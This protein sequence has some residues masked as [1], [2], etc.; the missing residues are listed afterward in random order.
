MSLSIRPVLLG[1][2]YN[3]LVMV[4]FAVV[5]GLALAHLVAQFQWARFF[6]EFWFFAL[7]ALSLSA[8]FFARAKKSMALGALLSFVPYYLVVVP[9]AF[10]QGD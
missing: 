6:G 4:G 2:T 7:V 9:L 5:Y 3:L 8:Y 1:L 10:F